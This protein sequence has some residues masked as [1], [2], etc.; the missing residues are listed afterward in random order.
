MYGVA[1]ALRELG[2][3]DLADRYDNYINYLRTTAQTVFY[4]GNGNV[5]WVTGILDVNSTPF[6]GNYFGASDPGDPYEVSRV[7]R[8]IHLYVHPP[9]HPFIHTPM[10]PYN[11]DKAARFS[12]NFG[13]DGN[14][15]DIHDSS[16]LT[17]IYPFIYP[18]KRCYSFCR[19]F[20]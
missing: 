10:H 5:S 8:Y 4:R 15:V 16:T 11:H 12:G 6:P 19:S 20:P 2:I 18:W 17:C 13:S 3:F 7:S 1:F 14:P 9:M